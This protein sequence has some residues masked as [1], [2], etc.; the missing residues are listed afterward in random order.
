MGG[1]LDGGLHVVAD[2]G[3]DRRIALGDG[4][5]GRTIRMLREDFAGR[6]L[7]FDSAAAQPYAMLAATRRAEGRP[8]NH[9]DCQIAAIDRSREASVATRAGYLEQAEVEALDPILTATCLFPQ[10]RLAQYFVD[11]RLP[12]RAGGPEVLYDRSV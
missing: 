7:P 2:V 12:A 8:I 10:G 5:V 4:K 9:A 1:L 11:P 6:V 3:V